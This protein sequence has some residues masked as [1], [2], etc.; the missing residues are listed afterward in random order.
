[1]Q[2]HSLV[3]VR[4]GRDS[5]LLTI[6]RHA[7]IHIQPL[8]KSLLRTLPFQPRRSNRL[9]YIRRP[10][11][12]IFLQHLPKP[13]KKMQIFIGC[14]DEGL[15]ALVQKIITHCVFSPINS[16]TFRMRDVTGEI[17]PTLPGYMS[18]KGVEPTNQRT[19]SMHTTSARGK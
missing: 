3:K 1:M 2:Q 13:I 15:R 16:Y 12:A 4:G 14:H 6:P 11:L 19:V 7:A 8:G 10:R 9:R 5:V 17:F 18:S